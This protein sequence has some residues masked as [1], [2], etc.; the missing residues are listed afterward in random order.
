[1]KY[2]I[3]KSDYCA[4]KPIYSSNSK[5]KIARKLIALE[6]NTYSLYNDYVEQCIRNNKPYHA[7]E[8]SYFI[9]VKGS[10]VLYSIE[11]IPEFALYA[12]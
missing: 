9:I 10:N 12:D 4:G 5:Y 1:M 2:E 7:F 3:V 6:D 11:D 8:S